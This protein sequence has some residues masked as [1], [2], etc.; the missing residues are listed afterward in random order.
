MYSIA[1][2]DY[3]AHPNCF[4]QKNYVNHCDLL[5]AHFIHWMDDTF[6]T[7]ILLVVD[8]TFHGWDKDGTIFSCVR[9]QDGEETL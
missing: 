5:Q 3:A 7:V 8:Y 4:M 2:S 1:H 6:K 9:G